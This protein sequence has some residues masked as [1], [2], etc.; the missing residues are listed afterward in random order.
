MGGLRTQG[1]ATPCPFLALAS[2]FPPITIPPETASQKPIELIFCELRQRR[3][4]FW[5]RPKRSSE[6][7]GC[8]GH[9]QRAKSQQSNAATDGPRGWRIWV[10][11]GKLQLLRRPFRRVSFEFTPLL[12]H[13]A[14]VEDN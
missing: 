3:A 4:T 5:G 7:C 11:S 13:L 1:H 14:I 2:C 8:A 10:V 12:V 6:L 9:N